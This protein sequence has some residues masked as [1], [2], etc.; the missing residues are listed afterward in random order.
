MKQELEKVATQ[1]RERHKNTVFTA[2]GISVDVFDPEST[3]VSLTVDSRHLQLAG[4]VHGGVYALLVESA[5]SVC[6]ALNVD[7]TKEMVFG[8]EVNA[9]HLRPTMAGAKIS[10]TAKPLHRGKTT[11][12]YSAEIRDEQNRLIS[13]GRCTIVVKE[14]K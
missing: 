6:A 13:V 5:A 2:L 3:I 8:L 9:N 10:A 12:V 4:I 7:L 14:K 11:H 1:L